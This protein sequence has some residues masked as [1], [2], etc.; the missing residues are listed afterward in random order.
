MRFRL[1]PYTLSSIFVFSLMGCPEPF[2]EI[3]NPKTKKVEQKK[4]EKKEKKKLQSYEEA[5]RRIC[6]AKEKSVE[7]GQSVAAWINQHVT[8]KKAR[9]W[10]IG[11][12]KIK[13]TERKAYFLAEAK[14]GGQE[15]CPLS[16]H[17]FKN[18][19]KSQP[20]SRP[21]AHK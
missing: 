9:Y 4:K 19:P 2:K 18:Y 5:W 13:P 1:F 12:A 7:E 6:H 10:W 3:E 14:K 16:T 17:L 15:K 8:N 20:A 21:N 11:Y